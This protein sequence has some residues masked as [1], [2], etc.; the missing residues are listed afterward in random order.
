M[1]RKTWLSVALVIIA[2]AI[3][4]A[5]AFK[6][7]PPAA[8]LQKNTLPR[9]D[10]VLGMPWIPANATTFAAKQLGYFSDEGLDITLRPYPSGKL[11][12]AALLDGKTDL[13]IVAETPIVLAALNGA[14]FS[15]LATLYESGTNI[16]MIA[17]LDRGISKPSDLSGRKLGTV[18]G[19]NAEFI[20]DT[21]LA[22]HKIDPDSIVR[23][24]LTPAQSVDALI[25]GDVDAVTIWAPYSFDLQ[26]RMKS[27]AAI[28]SDAEMYTTTY[29]LVASET[30][31]KQRPEQMRGILVALLKGS[32]FLRSDTRAA[33]RAAVQASNLNEQVINTDANPADFTVALNQSLLIAMEDQARWA[34][35]RGLVEASAVPNFLEW[36]HADAL[37]AVKP[38]AVSLIR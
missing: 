16:A 25:A 14:R 12:L 13:A 23:V 5:A 17:R 31:L 32:A 1:S 38:D 3:A 20:Q 10:L 22:L 6:F 8:D 26:Q 18:F 27:G 7:L 24:N 37:A 34:I 28:F 19:T 36:I 11:A 4:I 33:M 29:N 9:I 15:V 35:K 2:A 30:L 21:I